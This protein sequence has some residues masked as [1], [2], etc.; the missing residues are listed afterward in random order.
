MTEPHDAAS[1]SAGSHTIILLCPQL[2]ACPTKPTA[3]RG[4]VTVE[5]E[6]FYE[7][8]RSRSLLTLTQPKAGGLDHPSTQTAVKKKK[9]QRATRTH[10]AYIQPFT[11]ATTDR[12]T[13]QQLL[14]N[15]Q[16][17]PSRYRDAPSP[18]SLS[19]WPSQ[20]RVW[21]NKK[22]TCTTRLTRIAAHAFAV[23][24][25]A[26][27]K[28][29]SHL[30]MCCDWTRGRLSAYPSP[31][32]RQPARPS[33]IRCCPFRRPPMPCLYHFSIPVSHHHR[34]WTP[35]FVLPS[36]FGCLLGQ[37]L[38]ESSHG[39]VRS[40]QIAPAGSWMVADPRRMCGMALHLVHPST[41]TT[42]S[43]LCQ[44]RQRQTLRPAAYRLTD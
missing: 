10:P 8:G 39:I 35:A 34:R 3:G 31:S 12:Y 9:K 24:P 16:Q 28:L 21:T 30:L 42:E 15:W 20:T 36:T 2:P 4:R 11:D 29:P 19:S 7:V 32:I 25:T 5:L 22:P 33:T 18:H 23:P 1:H 6:T 41:T 13:T 38:A 26:R 37:W 17:T 40:E 44:S 43:C 14:C 27:A